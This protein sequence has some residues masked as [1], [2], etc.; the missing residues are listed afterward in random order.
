M[1][2]WYHGLPPRVSP[3]VGR[4]GL[5]AWKHDQYHSLFPYTVF[6]PCSLRYHQ[7]NVLVDKK[8]EFERVHD[9]HGLQVLLVLVR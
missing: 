5:L 1:L 2:H 6:N 9:Q 8:T 4:Q 3:G 7:G